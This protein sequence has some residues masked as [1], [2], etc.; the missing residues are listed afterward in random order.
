[1][2]KVVIDKTTTTVEKLSW[3]VPLNVDKGDYAE[4]G[5]EELYDFLYENYGEPVEIDETFYQD[6]LDYVDNEIIK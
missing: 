1:M 2:Y 5:V 4:M 6:H 3:F